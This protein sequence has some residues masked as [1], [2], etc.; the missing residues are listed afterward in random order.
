[1][2]VKQHDRRQRCYGSTVQ[3]DVRETGL[4]TEEDCRVGNQVAQM[5]PAHVPYRHLVSMRYFE[6]GGQLI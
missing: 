5:A 6:T 1:M 2:E 3:L 4:Q